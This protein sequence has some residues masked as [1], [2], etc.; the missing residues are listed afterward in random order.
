MTEKDF[1]SKTD[2]LKLDEAP[3][4]VS[5]RKCQLVVL[6]GP[7]KNKKM[8]LNKNLTSIG[9]RE[10]NDLLLSD[11]TVSR[12]HLE[13]EYTSDSFLLKDM[14]STNGTY[15]NGS[16]VKE[17]YLAPGD[18]IKIG[19]TLLEFVAFDEKVSIEPSTKEIFGA[20]AGKSRKMR[21]IF[22]ILEKI[23]PTHA[24]VIIEGETGTGKD[25][26]ARAIHEHSTRRAHP[27]F[28]FDCSGVAPNLIESE[29]FGH[30]KGA[31]TGAI[32]SRSGVFEAAKG[33]TVFLDE[34]GELGLDLQPKLL[35]ALESREIR[36]VGANTPT[37][38][39]VRVISATNRNLKKEIVA[40][41]FREDLYYRMSVVKI[42]LPPLRERTE[43][44][45]LIVQKL[46]TDSKFNKTAT[47]VKVTRVEDD[48][49]KLLM[50][51]PWPGNVR[52]LAN[53]MERACSFVEG[54]TIARSHLDFI[55]AEMGD[56]EEG[57][58]RMKI[59]ADL[60]FKEAKQKIVE[61]FEK[62][63]LE[64]LLK[65]HNH[66]LSKAAREA[67]VDRKHIRNLLKK[68]GIPT[69]GEF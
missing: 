54:N 59:D 25:L 1:E 22:A 69:K 46:L 28:V 9:K 7:D 49:L 64:D 27:Y 58:D 18:T 39:D 4:V 31:F 67:K 47:G 37:R 42:L 10:N 35:R 5:L 66:N 52:E 23:A 44:I 15:L 41:R 20:M 11:K 68:Y 26:V 48:A 21:Q 16:K 2:L 29:L 56:T 45:P 53:V 38:I 62:E 43:D 40:G 24:T 36:R 6:E 51:Y 8:T 57:T 17:A 12:N 30:E 34:I 3:E 14:G 19:N 55:F 50:R 33:G 60:P 13:I 65:R 32:R 63:Y 61:V